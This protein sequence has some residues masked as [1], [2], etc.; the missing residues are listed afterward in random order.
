MWSW[1]SKLVEL[2]KRGLPLIVTTLVKASGATPREVGAKMIVLSTG[3]FFGTI[4][5]GE[6]EKKVLDDAKMVF[7]E[8]NSTTK[9]YDLFTEKG[10]GCGGTAEILFECMNS[11]PHL[12]IFGAGHVGLAL[13]KALA[14]TPFILHLVDEREEWVHSKTVDGSVIRHQKHWKKFL[15]ELSWDARKTYI[16]IMTPHHKFD[17]HI[18][19]YV[20]DKPAKYIGLMG[21]VNKWQSIKSQLLDKGIKASDLERVHCPI[22]LPI[23]GKS[24]PEIAISISAELL[25]VFYE[26]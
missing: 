3:E 10:E 7:V 21:S 1:A 19:E 26:R 25:K 15:E 13:C 17:Q 9:S 22:G 6:L 11:G 18:A 20:V 14:E 2:E 5:G 4:G 16:A 12:Y 24:P 8:G 23:G